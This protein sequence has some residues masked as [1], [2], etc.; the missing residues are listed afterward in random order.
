MPKFLVVL[1]AL[2]AGVPAIAVNNPYGVHTLELPSGVY[3]WASAL[4]Q[5]GGYC[6]FFF[7]GITNSTSGPSAWWVSAVQSAYNRGMNPIVRIGTTYNGGY[8]SKPQAD[9]DGRY[10]AFAAAVKRVVQGLPRQNGYTLY[11]EILNEVNS[12]IEWS[13]SPNPAEYARCLVDCHSAIVSIGDSRIKVATAGL[14]GGSSFLA[15]MFALEPASLW[16][17]DVLSSHCYSL[18]RPPELNRHNGYGG[19]ICIDSYQLDVN[20]CTA[21]GRSGVQVMITETGYC[22]GQSED[23]SY[24]LIDEE[25]RADYIMRAFRDY[26][27][28]W[29]EVLAVTPFQFRDDGWVCFDWVNPGSGT[30]AYGR[31]TSARRQYFD[32]Y[33]LA[34]PGMS[35]GAISG[36][37]TESAFGADVSGA[38]VVLT[39]GSLSTTSNAKGNYFFP[40]EGN[41]SFLAPG[42]YSISVSKT[43]YATRS[44]SNISV[45]AGRNT[46]VNVALTATTLGTVTGTVRDPITGLGLSGVTIALSPGGRSTTSG[47]DGTYTLASVSP[48]TYTLSGT[49]T[50]FRPYS[51][52]GLQISAG[53]TATAD[54]YMAPGAEPGGTPLITVGE[55][56]VDANPSSPTGLAEGWQ[57]WDGANHPDIFLVD[58]SER[59]SGRA[60]QRIKA[61]N[62]RWAGRWT[63]YN[64]CTT[65]VRYRIEAWVKTSGTSSPAFLVGTW[66]R[67]GEGVISQFQAHP[68]MTG[69][70]GWTLM[71]ASSV[72]P[73]FIDQSTGRLRVEMVGPATGSGYVWFDRVWVGR[74]PDQTG[75]PACSVSNLTAAAGQGSVGLSWGNP[76]PAV[77]PTFSGVMIRRMTERYPIT[78][79]EGTLVADVSAPATTCTDSAVVSGTRYYYAAFAHKAGPTDFSKG[80][81][82]SAVPADSSPPTTPVVTD[83]GAYTRTST[84]IHASWS[85]SDP[86]SGIS[87]YDCCVG[88]SPGASDVVGWT[89]AGSDTSRNIACSL[90]NGQ[91]YYVSVRAFNGV[92]LVSAVGT[93]DGITAVDPAT[94]IS[95]VKALPDGVL[96][97]LQNKN[98]SACSCQFPF[99]IYI[100]ED[101]R[102]AGIRVAG[103]VPGI[104]GTRADVVGWTAGAALERYISATQLTSLA[105]A[106]P[107]T[108]LAMASTQLGGGDFMVGSDPARGQKGVTGGAG[109]NN[110][111]LL[112][113]TWGYV[114]NSGADGFE[115]DGGYGG[116]VKVKAVGLSLPTNGVFAVVT[117]LVSL[118]RS[119]EDLVPFLRARMQSDIVVVP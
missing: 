38:T 6:K 76:D 60:S 119:G 107:P 115:L 110:V 51:R 70:N 19:D 16:A 78:S 72:A 56:D 44:I 79:A 67:W 89:N 11:I 101:D 20:A 26:W 57:S 74:D 22:I 77:F 17:W 40:N 102:S 27:S 13:M 12:Q 7:Y 80:A 116:P 45:S 64:T 94:T 105:Y 87:R 35:Q 15:Q 108:P 93:S 66:S 61:G 104:Y 118:E 18:N 42:T 92:G 54:F 71:A 91:T 14:A 113:R 58:T 46:V 112:V 33:Y 47:A 98:R 23:A 4:V 114:A 65:G 90:S 99:E 48:S 29:P 117:G 49:K 24:P 81:Y 103:S 31:P 10:T 63:E 37:I 9:A 53:G 1:L 73:Y 69:A 2:C 82:A 8:W 62:S 84:F 96:V 111:G 83:D 55:M 86:Q 34:K 41:L 32:V 106:G 59:I 100:Q 85:A 52:A 25:N 88:T 21:A 39:P 30:D 43:G 95:Q 109:V 5:Q 36:K 50:G 97:W 28:Q 68:Q 75:N 3:D